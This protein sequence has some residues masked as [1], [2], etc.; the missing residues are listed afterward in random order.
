MPPEP[1]HDIGVRPAGKGDSAADDI[2][3]ITRICAELAVGIVEGNVAS[4][5]VQRLHLTV[6]RWAREGRPLEAIQ[7]AVHRGFRRGTDYLE[8][9]ASGGD[10]A[11]RCTAPRL[12]DALETT[13]AAVSAAY[14][15]ELRD[16][17]GHGHT[18]VHALTSALLTGHPTAV[19]ARASGITVAAAYHV[20]AVSFPVCRDRREPG[21][22]VGVAIR[23]TLRSAQS[24]L[25]SRFA[26]QAL[27]SLHRG[28][29]TILVPTT[30]ATERDIETLVGALTAATGVAV[31]ATAVRAAPPDIPAC[32]EHAH[33]LLDTVE[34]LGHGPGLHRLGALALEYQLTRP[35]PGLRMLSVLLDPLEA[36]PE[37]A[38]TLV[39]HLGNDLNRRRTAHDLN[40]HVNTVD[41]RIKRVARLIGMDPTSASGLMYVR[42]AL[43]ARS[44]T[45][46]RPLCQLSQ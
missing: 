33:E 7:H 23:R 28:G 34:R 46:R 14:I 45:G 29:G 35:G 37:L 27:S 43:V 15:D 41:Y 9:H 39:R 31:A 26:G 40:V 12:A 5:A 44:F 3:A 25:A 38:E 42:A 20:V 17:A 13:A 30:V 19:A 32:S 18:A 4:N 10:E 21:M 1:G 2:A 8:T 36:H 24:T 11:V 6:T 22:D 16:M